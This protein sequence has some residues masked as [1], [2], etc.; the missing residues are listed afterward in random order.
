MYPAGSEP[1]A[2]YGP[3][4]VHKLKQ[5]EIL[6]ELFLRPIVSNIGTA[7]YKTVKYLAKLLSPLGQ[8]DCT[9]TNTADFIKHIRKETI[10]ERYKK[11]SFD[12]K[13]LFTNVPLEKNNS[14]NLGKGI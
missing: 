6:F 8:S 1:G 2:F 3:T 11:I 13:N 4:K 10:R 7:T 12:V 9:V 5:G 14:S